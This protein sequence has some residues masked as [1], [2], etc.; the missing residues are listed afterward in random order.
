MIP[1]HES[2]SEGGLA[3]DSILQAAVVLSTGLDGT[4]VRPRWQPVNPP[5]P[6]VGTDFCA[7]GV[8]T[9]DADTNTALLSKD[10]TTSELHRHETLTVTASFYGH[11]AVML[12][13]RLRDGLMMAVNR[14]PFEQYG[15][16]LLRTQSVTRLA[17]LINGTWQDR[18]DLNFELRRH[19]IRSFALPTITAVEGVVQT[20]K[21][22]TPFSISETSS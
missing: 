10:S 14:A 18:A 20:D 6:P 3:L 4:L 15:I 11:N 13:A 9:L 22:S 1:A 12:A 17:T 19:I 7:I 2:Y 16:R 8:T 21:T 5:Y